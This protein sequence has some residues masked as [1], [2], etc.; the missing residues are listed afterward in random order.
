MVS[1]GHLAVNRW[2]MAC[3]GAA[4]GAELPHDERRAQGLPVSMQHWALYNV[5][6]GMLIFVD[7][8]VYCGALLS[9]VRVIM[10]MENVARD[11]ECGRKKS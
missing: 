1:R 4:R 8:Y 9:A 2:Q 6:E 11:R 10:Q 3:G 7:R 5:G